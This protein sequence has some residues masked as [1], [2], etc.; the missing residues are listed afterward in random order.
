MANLTHPKSAE[1]PSKLT[2]VSIV[3]TVEV[4]RCEV[5]PVP[6][7]TEQPAVAEAAAGTATA[8]LAATAP[9][10]AP[11]APDAAATA[12]PAEGQNAKTEVS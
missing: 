8:E 4:P 9:E 2:K 3:Y 1:H 7:A 12:V 5:A 6:P 11:T 10:E